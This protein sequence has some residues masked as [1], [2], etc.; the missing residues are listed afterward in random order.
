MMWQQP[1]TDWQAEDDVLC[2][3]YNRIKGNIEFL[4]ELAYILYF[5][6]PLEDMGEDKAE[7]EYPYA[8]E[9]NRI[10]DNL[11]LLAAGSYHVDVGTK[12]V[13]EENGPYIAY[14]DLNRI[15]SAILQ[16]YENM[17]RIK[18][19]KGRLPFRLGTRRDPF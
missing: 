17:N 14:G 2:S 19:V 12:I 5:P 16:L 13:Y 7:E 3:D 9:I 15:E 6:F 4:K 8:D 11:E 18:A 10:A 1:K